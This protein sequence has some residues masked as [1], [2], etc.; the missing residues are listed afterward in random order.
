MMNLPGDG[1]AFDG[2]RV[3]TQMLMVTQML[4]IKGIY[5][6]SMFGT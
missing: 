1:D 2:C 3:V 6:R 5:G 4:I